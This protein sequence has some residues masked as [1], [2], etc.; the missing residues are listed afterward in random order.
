MELN[1][2]QAFEA[3]K[4]TAPTPE[5]LRAL[6]AQ[7]NV[8][9][10]GTVTVA[11]GGTVDGTPNGIGNGDIARSM[12]AADPNIRIIDNTAASAFMESAAF[13]TKVAEAYNISF[14]QQTTGAN[15]TVAFDVDNSGYLKNTAWLSNSDGFLFLDRNLN[16]Q[17]DAGSELF[18]NSAVALSARGLNGMRWVD[19][20]YDG[21]LSALDPVWNELKV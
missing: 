19:S 17:I 6:V 2:A 5:T 7:V 12:A 8:N 3:L 1:L 14:D 18:S 21:Q 10:T 13:K 4:T 9:A 16:G 20:N 11:Y 15:K